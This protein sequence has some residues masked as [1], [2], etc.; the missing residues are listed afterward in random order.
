MMRRGVDKVGAARLALERKVG[1]PH[2]L[3]RTFVGQ[4]AA[5]LDAPRGEKKAAATGHV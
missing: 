4:D 3:V 5:Q 2:L 1:T